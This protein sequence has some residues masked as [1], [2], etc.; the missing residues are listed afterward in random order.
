VDQRL[1]PQSS[2][3]AGGASRCVR[4][5]GG[6]VGLRAGACRVQTAQCPWAHDNQRWPWVPCRSY[7]PVL[8]GDSPCVHA[9]ALLQEPTFADKLA[10]LEGWCDEHRRQERMKQ[11]TKMTTDWDEEWTVGKWINYCLSNPQTVPE[12]HRAAFEV[13]VERSGYGQVRAARRQRSVRGHTATSGGR[14]S[15]ARRVSPCSWAL[16][17]MCVHARCCRGVRLIRRGRHDA[18][19]LTR[20]PRAPPPPPCRMPWPRRRR[21]RSGRCVP[22]GLGLHRQRCRRRMR[23]RPGLLPP[24]SPALRSWPRRG[25]PNVRRRAAAPGA[26]APRPR[27]PRAWPAHPSSWL[28]TSDVTRCRACRPTACRCASM[29]I[30][31]TRWFGVSALGRLAPWRSISCSFHLYQLLY[32]DHIFIIYY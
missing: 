24:P 7:V 18:R 15:P 3:R 16:P 12:E 17:P 14:G 30:S 23:L 32:H 26:R 28:R 2:A 10:A 9:R 29:F 13:A 31:V 22:G 5:G 1:P 11:N 27:R 19:G 6:A 21:R 8:M 4:G 25:P 20:C